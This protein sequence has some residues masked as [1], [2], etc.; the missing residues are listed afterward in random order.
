MKHPLFARYNARYKTTAMK[1]LIFMLKC[2]I[3]TGMMVTGIESMEKNPQKHI[4]LGKKQEN[5]T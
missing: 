4:Q 3:F 5:P 2:L 1:K